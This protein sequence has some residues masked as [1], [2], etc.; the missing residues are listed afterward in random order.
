VLSSDTD[1]F[2]IGNF[3]F[4]SGRDTE[5]WANVPY[6]IKD[7]LPFLNNACA[8]LRLHVVNS[9]EF[10]THTMFICE[11]VD[12]ENG[13]NTAKPLIYGD[14]Q[15]T[16]KTSTVEA[17]QKFKKSG[18]LP[19]NRA[20]WRCSLCGYVYGGD[21]PFEELPDTWRCPLCGVGKESFEKVT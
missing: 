1:P 12:A 5:K 8:C 10:S 7:G 16:M 13:K 19:E 18:T 17:F 20:E 21:I 14:Y 3:G 2:V 4:Q 11:L 6:T 15:K 9:L